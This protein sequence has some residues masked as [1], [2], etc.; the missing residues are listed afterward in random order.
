MF[1]LLY[2]LVI[3]LVLLFIFNKRFS[4]F[5][6]SLF[7]KNMDNL[8]DKE[9]LLNQANIEISKNEAKTNEAQAKIIA[10]MKMLKT[11]QEKLQSKVNENKDLRTKLKAKL[12]TETDEDKKLAIQET[13]VSLMN[14]I[15]PV[16]ERL[17]AITTNITNLQPTHDQAI[18]MA[19]MARDTY[20][21]QRD[22]IQTAKMKNQFSQAQKNIAESISTFDADQVGGGVNDILTKV[23]TETAEN[24]AKLEVAMQS[25]KSVLDANKA[26][27]IINEATDPFADIK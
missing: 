14:S 25:K 6:K 27:K 10:Q 3:I 1:T 7:N 11:E 21:E 18:E 23:D 24:T 15:G 8:E 9:A 4:I 16:Q 12:E 17:D 19:N 26:R 5:V 22:N 20:Q 13:A 2:I